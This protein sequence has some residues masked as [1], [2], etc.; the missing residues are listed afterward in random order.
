MKSEL[1][2]PQHLA[3]KAIIYIRQSTPNQTLTNQESSEASICL[4]K[5]LVN[6]VGQ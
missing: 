2:T 4:N 5:K 3:N 1:I 6:W